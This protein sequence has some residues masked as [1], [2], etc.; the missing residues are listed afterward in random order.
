MK[1]LLL[2]LVIGASIASINAQ[3]L[4]NGDF[5]QAASPLLPGVATDCPG[6]GPGLYTME[7]AGPYAG[8]QSAKMTTI[9]DPATNQ[10]LGWGSDTIPGIMSQS[11]TGAMPNIGS[12]SLNFAYKHQVMPGDTAIIICQVL[13]TMTANPNDDV[14]LYQAYGAYAGTAN[15]WATASLPLQAFGTGTANSLI[16]VA[17]SS[18]NAAFG[19]GNGIPGSI[20][21]LDNISVSGGANVIELN[22]SVNVYPNPASTELNFLAS[23]AISG[24]E[25]YGMDGKLALSATTTTVDI[26]SLPNGIYHYSVM[27]VTGKVLKGKVSK[28]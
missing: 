2:S 15:T 9:L 12:M 19:V 3:V 21:W 18:M 16:V 5:E 7:T 22:A 28:I 14:I 26:T 6:W 27:T 10:L 25:I 1:K 17:S 24:V 13:D 8:T 20:L 4:T 23:E 11:F